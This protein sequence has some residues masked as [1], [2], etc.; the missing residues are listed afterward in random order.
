MPYYTH[1]TRVKLLWL[2]AFAIKYIYNVGMK[3]Q[4]PFFHHF[5]QGFMVQFGCILEPRSHE[6]DQ[7]LFASEGKRE[8]KI[9]LSAYKGVNTARHL[10]TPYF[11]VA[12]SMWISSLSR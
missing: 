3:Q 4:S 8:V 5:C 10:L 1:N 6:Q 9:L 12:L 7:G 2:F 11:H